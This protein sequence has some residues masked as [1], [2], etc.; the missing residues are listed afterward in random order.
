MKKLNDFG[1]KIGGAKKD[2]WAIFKEATE[3]EQSKM[4]R[5]AA[6]W[7]HP[8]YEA[9]EKQGIPREVL[10]WRDQ[11]RDAVAPK[12]VKNI[13]IEEYMSFVLDVK[14]DAE[15]CRTL[16]D[17]KKFYKGSDSEIPG[18]FKYLEKASDDPKDKHWKYASSIAKQLLDGNTVLRYV[19][20]ID[21]IKKDSD[22]YMFMA[23]LDE[24][25]NKKYEIIK[26]TAENMCS[27]KFDDKRFKN[28]ITLPNSIVTFFDTANYT[29][30][31]AE[32]DENAVY[33]PMYNKKTRIGVALSE[34]E[35]KNIIAKDKSKRLSEKE[36]AKKETFLPPHLSVIERTGSSYNFF[37]F[38]DGGVLMARYGLRGG[39]FGNYTT[40]KDRIGSINMAYDAFEDLYKAVG[41]SPKDISLGGGLAIAFGARGRGNAMAHYELEKN[42]INMTKKRGAGS[43]AHE[44]GHAMD[45]YIGK[46]FGVYGFASANLSK[47]P[48]SVKKLVEAFKEQ[49]GKETFFYESSKF[50]DGEY[51]KAGNG[52]WSSAH[53]MFARAF[54]CYVK[55]KLDGRRSDYLVGH[56]ECAVSGVM[57]AYPRK[58]EREFINQCFDEF[59]A[60]MIE[61]GILSKYEPE[62]K[63]EADNIEEV[64]IEDLLFEGQGGQ[65]MFF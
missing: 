46:K 22:A 39:E 3:D 13:G 58:D 57:V 60:D 32:S 19:Y 31:L 7:K 10:F 65:M 35:A 6:L 12:P 44:W 38:S 30:L 52:Y 21:R 1:Q 54:A 55:D 34:L 53:E 40:S 43:L 23:T 18:I 42:V 36:D 62:A 4:A 45:A 29:S 20:H 33:V 25:E 41:I 27:E 11:M 5:K 17:I 64:N 37:K 15:E 49:D 26:C 48:E 50:F 51:K 14:S 56:A 61:K 28:V 2:I 24:K 8:K 63:K 59:F 47:M 16:D 9:L